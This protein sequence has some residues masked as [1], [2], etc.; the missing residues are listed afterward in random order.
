PEGFPAR[1][2]AEIPDDF[3]VRYEII[4]NILSL[5]AIVPVKSFDY[6]SEKEKLFGALVI[7]TYLGQDYVKN[8]SKICKTEI[9]L[10]KGD[11]LIAGTL[12]A[13]KTIPSQYVEELEKVIKRDSEDRRSWILSTDLAV[14]NDYYYQGFYPL[15]NEGQLVGILSVSL[16]KKDA[17]AKTVQAILFLMGLML[18]CI[19]GAVPVSIFFSSKISGPIGKMLHMVKDIAQ[20][21]GDLTKRI[22]GVETGDEIADLGKGFNQF[23]EKIQGIVTR[24]AEN[25]NRLA[26]SAE[27]LSSSAK[28]MAIGADQQTSQTD[29]VATAMEEMAATVIE[30]AKNSSEARDFAKE[31]SKVAIQGGEVVKDT[32]GKMND[33]AGK[34][35]ESAKIIEELGGSSNQI[36]EIIDVI[37]EIADQTNLLALNAAIEAARAGEQGRGFAVVADEVRKLAERTTRATKE[38]ADMIKTIQADTGGAVASMEDGTK[39]VEAGAELGKKAGESLNKIVTVVQK[40]MDMIQQIAVSAEE[41]SV[42]AE[43]ISSNVESVATVIKQTAAASQQSSEAAE[44]LS[45]LAVDLQKIVG[46]FKLQ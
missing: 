13:Y 32:I 40:V 35:G 2:D 21:E 23:L 29:Q 5:R 11:R 10:F 34:V 18:L 43:E 25:T 4:G 12:P 17:R 45:N 16:S 31:A 7:D 26:S 33:I 1:F 24:V 14:N 27:E 9:N 39:E 20:G 36:G 22:E 44:D 42:A 19:G 37:D 38:I 41:Q 8:V 3:V 6:A 46:Q 15:A 28:Q 30:V